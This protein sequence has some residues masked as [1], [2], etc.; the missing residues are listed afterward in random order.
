MNTN[1]LDKQN[2]FDLGDLNTLRQD[3]LKSGTDS[4]AS[5]EALKKAAQQFESIFTQMLLKSMRKA[6]EA[7]EDKESPFN[8]SSVKFFEE[9]HDQQLSVE[10][11]GKGSLG[12][13]DLI[14]QQLAP[15]GEGYTPASVLRTNANLQS[16]KIANG[17]ATSHVAQKS[18]DKSDNQDDF[19]DPESFVGALWSHAKEA[20]QK[21]GL[22]PA[23]MVAQAALE[24]GWGKHVIAK[25][26]GSSSFNLFNIKSDKSWYGE[27]AKKLTL[28]FEQ[29]LP[30]Q[31]QAHFRAYDSIKES[32]SDYVDFLQNNPRYE[33][34]LKKVKEPAQYLDALQEAGYATDPNYAQKIKSVLQRG[35]FKQM[36][37]SLI[38]QGV[39]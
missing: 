8:S 12:L 16:D 32:I 29:G 10:L 6:N 13:A 9:M 25:P 21:I 39:N 28:E 23:V 4:Q 11:A 35:E 1:P 18:A 38:R 27:S 24:T 14:V 34:A 7:M 20:A 26:D 5:N 2:F 15:N 3:A 37:S 31:K 36:L 33:Q 30:V 19:K 17:E 22:N